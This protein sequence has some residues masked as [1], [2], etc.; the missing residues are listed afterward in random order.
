MYTTIQ[1][2]FLRGGFHNI[3]DVTQYYVHPDNRSSKGTTTLLKPIA[4]EFILFS[5]MIESYVKG[6][7]FGDYFVSE[8]KKLGYKRMFLVS[9]VFMRTKNI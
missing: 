3:S 4:E 5:I 8:D 6:E 1:I 9:V 2:S 7:V